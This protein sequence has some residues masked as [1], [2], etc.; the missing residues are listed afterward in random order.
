MIS[1]PERQFWQWASSR[2]FLWFLDRKA[3]LILISRKKLHN[4]RCNSQ[5]LL[6]KDLVVFSAIYPCQRG[7]FGG[8]HQPVFA[9]ASRLKSSLKPDFQKEASYCQMQIIIAF[10][11]R[12]SGFQCNIFVREAVLAV[13]VGRNFYG[14]SIEKQPKI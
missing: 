10:E 9:M 13:G 11:E 4:V 5:Q 1:L 7:S 2:I 12:L 8:G 14:F 6:K 3:A